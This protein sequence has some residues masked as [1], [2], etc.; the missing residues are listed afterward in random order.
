[1][2]V[3]SVHE[4]E[5]SAN[6]YAYFETRK[7]AMEAV[8][9]LRE[10]GKPATLNRAVIAKLPKRRLVVACLNQQGYARVSETVRHWEGAPAEE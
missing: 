5:D 1:M 4:L 10:E 9:Q 6:G 3:W 8:T 2:I 7:E